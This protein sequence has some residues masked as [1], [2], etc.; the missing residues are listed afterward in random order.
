VTVPTGPSPHPGPPPDVVPVL[1]G[2]PRPT[3]EGTFTAFLGVRFDEP[4]ADGTVRATVPLRP[5]FHQP[6]GITHGGIYAAVAEEVA[7]A[8]TFVA[9]RSSGRYAVGQSN[10]THFL[11]PTSSGTLHVAARPHHR[12]R[13]SWVWTVEFHDDEGRPCA[14]STVTMAVRDR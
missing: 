14:L 8:A 10:L 5:E 2:G 13:T 6:M 1:G 12:G 9:V 7:S 3:F 4:E 11:R